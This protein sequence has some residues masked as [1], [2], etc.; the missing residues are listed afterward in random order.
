LSCVP[1]QTKGGLRRDE[2]ETAFS[3][4]KEQTSRFWRSGDSIR[5]CSVLPELPVYAKLN[6]RAGL[7]VDVGSNKSNHLSFANLLK[8]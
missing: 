1:A 2:S 5:Q 3:T 8:K 4:N 7:L 6:Q